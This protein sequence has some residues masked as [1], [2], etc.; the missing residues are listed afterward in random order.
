MESPDRRRHEGTDF[1]PRPNL[2][3]VR[4]ASCEDCTQYLDSMQE[5]NLARREEERKLV[6]TCSPFDVHGFCWVCGSEE[7][8]FVISPGEDSLEVVPNW[9]EQLVCRGCHL[10]NRLR[11]SI[12]IL[13]A[14]YQPRKTSSIYLTEQVTPVYGV[15][16]SRYANLVG[17]EFLGDFLPKGQSTWKRFASVRWRRV[18]NENLGCLSFG[19]QAF[20]FIL[21][22][23]VFE[24]TPDYLMALQECFR[25]WGK[26]RHVAAPQAWD[27]SGKIPMPARVRVAGK[28]A[29]GSLYHRCSFPA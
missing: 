24:H 2:E 4:I 9:R 23:D 19:T 25:A 21:S 17:S 7:R 18:R 15:L 12:H 10:N 29:P 6:A 14:E 27:C 1:E 3:I 20:D 5:T 11:A 8:F 28:A 26:R 13:E 22:F 16:R